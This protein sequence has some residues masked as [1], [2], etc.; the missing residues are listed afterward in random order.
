MGVVTESVQ[1]ASE[2]DDVWNLFIDP[3]RWLEWNTELAG[4]RDVRG[5]FDRPGRGYT[6]VWRMF[7]IERE[8]SWRV[9]GCEP[10]DWRTVE[11]VTPIG[12]AY[13]A[14]ETFERVGGHTAVTVQI[15]WTIPGGSIGRSFDAVV[16]QPL[17]RRALRA[18]AERIRGV[19]DGTA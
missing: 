2:L 19:L 4:M 16:G 8:G 3:D 1:V 5:P 18:N 7:G 11:G 13:T 14:R 10:R 15:S 6:Q 9:T 12:L 17:L